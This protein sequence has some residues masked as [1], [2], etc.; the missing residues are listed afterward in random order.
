MEILHTKKVYKNEYIVYTGNIIKKEFQAKIQAEIF[1]LNRVPELFRGEVVP[2]RGPLD[3]FC[4]T[5]AALESHVLGIRVNLGPLFGRLGGDDS[6][7]D[8]G[9]DRLA[10]GRTQPRSDVEQR[11]EADR[12][13]LAGDSIVGMVNVH[14]ELERRS[15][16]TYITTWD[17]RSWKRFS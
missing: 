8:A 16:K 15:Y 7:P 2:S 11:L 3:R 9:V 12:D 17:V 6:D 13:N 1:Q 14:H 10:L 4:I 5:G